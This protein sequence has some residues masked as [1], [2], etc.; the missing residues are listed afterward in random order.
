MVVFDQA[1]AD[2]LLSSWEPEVTH[3]HGGDLLKCDF[4]LRPA[5]QPG[6]IIGVE[7]KTACP[8]VQ[9]KRTLGDM[10]AGQPYAETRWRLTHVITGGSDAKGGLV[11]DAHKP[12]GGSVLH[13]KICVLFAYGQQ[14]HLF[15]LES[16]FRQV[17]ERFAQ[18]LPGGAAPQ[19]VAE[20]DPP[21]IDLENGALLQIL[22]F[23]V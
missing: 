9:R 16:F 15:D 2:H 3:D 7:V 13:E 1:T 22:A 12:R 18:H 5:R 21:P 23:Q 10:V 20:P 17:Q 8:G 14:E 19:R 6:R 11:P 4:A